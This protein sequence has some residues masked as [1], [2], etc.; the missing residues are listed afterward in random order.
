MIPALKLS[1][2]GIVNLP[3]F[4]F[5]FKIIEV[6][7]KGFSFNSA[8]IYFFFQKLINI[9]DNRTNKT[10]AANPNQSVYKIFFV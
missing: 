2:K 8:I 3:P 10:I 9:I 7:K 1:G 5:S 6:I 4:F